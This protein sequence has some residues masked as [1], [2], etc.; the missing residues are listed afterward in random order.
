MAELISPVPV[1]PQVLFNTTITHHPGEAFRPARWPEDYV[2]EAGGSGNVHMV[3]ARWEHQNGR[4]LCTAAQAGTY[5]CVFPIPVTAR[6]KIFEVRIEAEIPVGTLTV[7][8]KR[9]PFGGGGAVVFATPHVIANTGARVIDGVV[10]FPP[11][12][13]RI[14]DSYTVEAEA[15]LAEGDFFAIYRYTVKAREIFSHRIEELL[16]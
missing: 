15:T 9:Y 11:H 14:G 2:D 16:T 1:G 10:I 3:R 12:L 4:T 7:T 13:T 8:P 5:K 6:T